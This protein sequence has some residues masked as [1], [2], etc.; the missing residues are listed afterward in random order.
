MQNKVQALK[1]LQSSLKPDSKVLKMI[2]EQ[3]DTLQEEHLEVEQHLERTEAWTEYLGQWRCHVQT[4]EYLEKE[5][6][7]K[8]VLIVHVPLKKDGKPQRP[9]PSWVC[10]RNIQEFHSMHKELMPYFSWL[11]DIALP[12]TSGAS[13]GSTSN[14][15]I[16]FGCRY[17][18]RNKNA[19][20]ELPIRGKYIPL[21]KTIEKFVK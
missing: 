19:Y 20:I 7:L 10:A 2:Q 8:A 6:V 11:K 15:L 18:R 12:S 4:V 16:S 14:S 13:S 1:A 3:V 5:D 9:N 17:S 21:T